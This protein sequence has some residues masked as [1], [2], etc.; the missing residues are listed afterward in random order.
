MSFDRARR[1]E[2]KYATLSYLP[3]NVLSNKSIF[4]N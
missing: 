3:L 1:A 2:Y 4:S